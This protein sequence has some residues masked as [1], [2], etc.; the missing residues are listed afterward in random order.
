VAEREPDRPVEVDFDPFAEPP[1]GPP[2]EPP[3]AAAREL[4]SDQQPPPPSPP[5]S[6]PPQPPQREARL[7]ADREQ[8]AQRRRPAAWPVWAQRAGRAAWRAWRATVAFL[9]TPVNL[10]AELRLPERL[11]PALLPIAWVALWLAAIAAEVVALALL[12]RG[13]ADAATLAFFLPLHAIGCVLL[14]I[15]IGMKFPPAYRRP[16]RYLWALLF[17]VN[18]FVPLIGLAASVLGVIGGTLFPN[19]LKPTAF[20][21]VVEPD[22]TATRDY[23]LTR[24]RGGAVRAR[25]RTQAMPAQARFEALLAIGAN[26]S[27]AA[28]AALREMLTDQVDDMRLLAYG[29][30]DRREKEIAEALARERLILEAAQGVGDR[31]AARPVFG[32]I[33]Q[34]YWELV[35]QEL[36]Q[37]DMAT[38]ATEQA[39]IHTEQALRGDSADGPRWLLIARVRMR[40]GELRE[41]D[42]AFGAALEYGMRRIA[43]LPYLAELRYRQRRYADVRRLMYE[44]G[45]QPAATLHAMQ[46]YWAA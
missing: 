37:G 35:Y 43:V 3:A 10:R 2:P 46:Q 38:Y 34:L 7:P 44:L 41:A 21:R 25:L 45:D 15:T 31:D 11:A 27:P 5:S 18:F 12:A 4:P 42:A 9:R 40:R 33:G 20:R 17:G 28:S 19:L 14:A 22:F 24:L 13:R 23:D 29:L 6:Q 1:G 32:R 39:L 30:L 8:T 16:R 36:V 26:H